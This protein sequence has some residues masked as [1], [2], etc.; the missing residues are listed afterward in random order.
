LDSKQT[1]LFVS[2]VAPLHNDSSTI[3]DFVAEVCSVLKAHY[4]N[5]ELVLVDDMSSDGTVQEVIELLREFECVRLIQL[6]KRSGIDL[7]ISAGLESVIGDYVAILIPNTDPPALIPKLIE[8][9]REGYGVLAGVAVNPLPKTAV[10]TVF[11]KLFHLYCRKYLGLDLIPG[12]THFRVLNRQSL[13]AILQIKDRYRQMRLITSIVGF[14]RST[15]TYRLLNRQNKPA[16][17]IPALTLF[18]DAIGIMVANSKHPLRLISRLGLLAS[19]LNLAYLL[20]V[21]AI[22][23]FKQDVA[24]GWTTLSFQQGFMFFMLF[25]ILTVLCEYTGRILEE[26]RQGPAYFVLGEKSSS[27]IIS[28]ATR[29]NVVHES[30]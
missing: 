30:R 1:E 28:D 29:R 18:E 23:L 15:F 7:A 22:Y 4:T 14:N 11:S 26:C 13:N 16:T 2:V 8:T 21:V 19:T 6:S 5:Y 20:Y 10:T 24:P 9:C 12:A 17:A 3:S 27:V 25:L